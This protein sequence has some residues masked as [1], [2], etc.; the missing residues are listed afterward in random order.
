MDPYIKENQFNPKF[1]SLRIA[2]GALIGFSLSVAIIYIFSF[3]AI[4]TLIAI[5]TLIFTFFIVFS[6]P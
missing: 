5:L 4:F 2:A 3:P 1:K 6:K